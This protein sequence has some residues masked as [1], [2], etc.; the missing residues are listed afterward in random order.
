M[1]GA[2]RLARVFGIDIGVHWTFLLLIAWIVFEARGSG[3][4]STLFAV[5]FVLA[6]F[7]CVVLHEL[8]HALAA[9]AFGVQTKHITLLPIG[10]VAAL[11]R[12][13]TQPSQELLIAIAGP[14]GNVVIAGVLGA[15]VLLF[16]DIEAPASVY[17]VTD[18]GL[19]T[20]LAVVNVALVVFNMLP[21]F[22]MDGGRVL[23]ALLAIRIDYA[24]ATRIAA[25]FGQVMA[26][27]FV[28]W[29]L[30]GGTPFLYLIA[31][32]VYF[33]GQAEA[34]AA[35]QRSVVTGRRVADAMI[36]D[37]R[38]F[39]LDTTLGEA[40]RALLAGSQQ[41]FPVLDA[42]G[43]VVGLL[44]RHRLI[45][46]L[47]TLGPDAP[48]AGVVERGLPHLADTD[49]L[50]R[51]IEQLQAHAPALPVERN[52]RLVGLLTQENLAEYLMLRGAV[53]RRVAHSP[54]GPPQD[55]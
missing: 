8:G 55:P 28:V 33:G 12:M 27:G 38:A 20:Q 41:D 36:T 51:A 52:G 3:L 25:T 22:P 48:I 23:R 26:L 11:E 1:R 40:G 24:K 44:L 53:R 19:L 6:I 21:A 13:P 14:A 43:R 46:G 15:V 32:F 31:I 2:L 9:R 7:F 37:F 54:P 42:E 18:V 29:A 30:L 34:A 4:T 50:E 39:P 45:E 35:A 49:N 10:G 16:S 5:G 17:T 47:S